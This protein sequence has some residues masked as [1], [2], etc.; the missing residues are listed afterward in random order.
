L[1][2]EKA[3]I[4]GDADGD[5]AVTISDVT[6]IQKYLAQLAVFDEAR[7]LIADADGDGN[8]TVSDA[9]ELQKHLAS[10]PANENIGKSVA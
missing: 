8:V 3:P 7:K 6:E 2:G 1:L 5:G 10:L 4:I 9:T